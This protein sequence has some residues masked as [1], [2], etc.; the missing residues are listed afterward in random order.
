MQFRVIL[1]RGEGGPCPRGVG[2]CAQEVRAGDVPD[3]MSR[4]S[5]PGLDGLCHE[6]EEFC[7]KRAVRPA[8]R[9]GAVFGR[10]DP[11]A[12]ALGYLRI[13]V[14]ERL[15]SVVEIR[16]FP[17]PRSRTR[18]THVR[19]GGEQAEFGFALSQVS[20]AR[21]GPPIAVLGHPL[22]CWFE[23]D[24]I[25]PRRSLDGAPKR[26]THLMGFIGFGSAARSDVLRR[27]P[28]FS[29]ASSSRR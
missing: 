11:R 14:R 4:F 17:G 12:Q 23:R 6:R 20:E 26:G 9:D 27:R 15:R 24:P 16:S 5:N 13:F 25:P 18:G 7:A 21:P 2:A 28:I 8:L 1:G 19:A 3:T 10:A 29:G 22:R